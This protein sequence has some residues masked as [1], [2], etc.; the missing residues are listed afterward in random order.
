MPEANAV[1]TVSGLKSPH[2]KLGLLLVGVIVAIVAVLLSVSKPAKAPGTAVAS[3]TALTA[4]K[5]IILAGR[6]FMVTIADTPAARAQGL[7][8]TKGLSSSQGMLFVFNPPQS[9][10]FW[11]KDMNYNLDILWFD[12]SKKL[13]YEQQN[14]AP[15]TYPN[16]YCAPSLTNYVL[17]VNSGTARQLQ[18]KLDDQLTTNY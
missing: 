2:L 15:S 14:L 4:G 16:N 5:T 6:T 11:M 17:E 3:Q 9:A 10:C 8:G 18:L 12:A 13:I 7:S 1:A